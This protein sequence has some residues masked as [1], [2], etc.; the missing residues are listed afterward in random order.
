MDFLKSH[1]FT[2]YKRTSDKPQNHQFLRR[3]THHH[4]PSAKEQ[5]KRFNPLNFFRFLALHQEEKDLGLVKPTNKMRAGLTKFYN[6]LLPSQL[7][8][9]EGS[10]FIDQM[11][12]F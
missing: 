4:I 12:Y 1:V 8:D 9:S 11:L 7:K 5:G 2:A 10:P 3:Q 6:F